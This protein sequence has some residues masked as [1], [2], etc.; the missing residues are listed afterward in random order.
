MYI[1]GRMKRF[2]LVGPNGLAYKIL[3]KPIEDAIAEDKAVAQVC[4]VSAH[5]EKGTGS[6]PKA[7]VVLNEG[8]DTIKAEERLRQLCTD[9]LSDYMRPFEYVFLDSMPKN[10]VGKT[11]IKRLENW[12]GR[13]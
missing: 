6:E 7:F 9:K 4:V 5:N 2:L 1:V 11:D 8:E 12:D 3:P 10:A 13:A